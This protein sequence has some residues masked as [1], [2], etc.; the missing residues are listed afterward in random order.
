[1][2]ELKSSNDAY[3]SK[4]QSDHYKDKDLI[5]LAWKVKEISQLDEM[6]RK[7]YRDISNIVEKIERDQGRPMARREYSKTV[8]KHPTKLNFIHQGGYTTPA[9]SCKSYTGLHD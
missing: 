7:C 8:D 1:M 3:S 2:L 6:G 4:L 5:S 9:N